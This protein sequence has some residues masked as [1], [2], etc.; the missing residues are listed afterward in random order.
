[1]QVTQYRRKKTSHTTILFH[2]FVMKIV[3]LG[4]G[5]LINFT[6]G[7]C[8]SVFRYAAEYDLP[9]FSIISLI[10]QQQ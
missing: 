3:V 10:I 5:Q 6:D 9:Q 4:P 1:M 2:H 8:Q 7:F